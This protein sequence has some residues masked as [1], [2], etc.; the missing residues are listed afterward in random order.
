MSTQQIPRDQWADYL[1]SFG[2]ANQTR[3]VSIDLESNE[4]GPQRIVEDQPLL[5]IETEPSSGDEATIVVVAGD[6]EGGE[7]AAL[8]HMVPDAS[9][10][11]V[12]AD[13][14]GRVEALDI[15]NPDGRTILQFVKRAA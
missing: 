5:A 12:K 8:T 15:E 13:D 10:V 11:W 1:S 2:A 9:A 4:L 7:P 3:P 14:E 6:P